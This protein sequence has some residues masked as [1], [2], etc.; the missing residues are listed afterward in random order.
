[1]PK[2]PKHRSIVTLLGVTSATQLDVPSGVGVGVGIGVG[3]GLGPGLGAG[4]RY[5]SSPAQSDSRPARLRTTRAAPPSTMTS[6]ASG[7]AL[8]VLAISRP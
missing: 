4:P 6:A 7:L 1:M 3:I 2:G 8:Y 5:P